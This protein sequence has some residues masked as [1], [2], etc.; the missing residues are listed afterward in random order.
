M[1]TFHIGVSDC[2]AATKAIRLFG[3]DAL[4]SGSVETMVSRPRK[5]SQGK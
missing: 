3:D 2:P 5:N 1:S 4:N